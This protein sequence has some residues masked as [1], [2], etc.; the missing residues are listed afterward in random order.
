MTSQERDRVARRRA[1]AGWPVK[2]F[3]LGEEPPD[4]LSDVTT[5]AERIAM[6]WPLALAAWQVAGRSLPTYDR[7]SMPGRLWRPGERRP[8]D[9]GA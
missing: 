1:R 9:D 3:R 2:R 4:D 8:E 6:M 5:A 7:S